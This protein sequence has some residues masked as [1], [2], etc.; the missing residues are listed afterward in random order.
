MLLDDETWITIENEKT[1]SVRFENKSRDK[2][3]GWLN[4]ENNAK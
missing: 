2:R 3:A 4:C 1:N